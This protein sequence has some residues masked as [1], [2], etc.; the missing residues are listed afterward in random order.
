MESLG[1]NTM[2]ALLAWVNKYLNHLLDEEDMT[3]TV[4]TNDKAHFS[5]DKIKGIKSNNGHSL[6]LPEMK[7]DK[8]RE[9]I[10]RN[11]SYIVHKTYSKS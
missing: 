3:W 8:Y 4:D 11:K 5:I 1:Y 7:M 10:K 9:D 2:A 6:E